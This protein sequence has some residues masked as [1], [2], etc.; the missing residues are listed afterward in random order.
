MKIVICS[1]NSKYIHSSLAPWYLLAGIREYS[2]FADNHDVVVCEGT[3]NEPSKEVYRRISVEAPDV[4]GFSC[5]IWNIEMV[6]EL[7]ALVKEKF[8]SCKIVLGGLEVS[9]NPAEVMS[10][11]PEVDFVICGEGEKPF[12]I[13]CDC[14]LS[15]KNG[16][17]LNMELYKYGVATKHEPYVEPFVTEEL[18]PTPFCK[19]Y[20]ENLNARIAYIETSRGCPY[21]CAFCLSGRCGGVRFWQTERAKQE[22][23]MLAGSGA[24]TVKF[25]DRTFNA[26]RERAYELWQFIIDSEKMYSEK[27]D[28]GIPSGVCFH[29][30]IAGD[31]L[32][33]KSLALLKTAP[34]GLIQLE[35]GLQSFNV[36]TLCLINRKTNITRLCENIKTLLSFNNMHIH[37]DLIAGLPREDLSGFKESFNTAYRLKPHALQLGFLKLLHGAD[38]REEPE[39]YPCV[40]SEKAPYEV[41]STPWMSQDDIKLLK[42]VEDVCDRL[43]N[44]GRFVRTID[45]LDEACKEIEPFDFYCAFAEYLNLLSEG[46][47]SGVGISLDKYTEM[48]WSFLNGYAAANKDIQIDFG[49]LRDLFVL[50]RLTT[51]S[52]GKL[53]GFLRVEDDRLRKV[54]LY[55]AKN[56]EFN[57]PKSTKRGVAILYSTAQAVFVDYTDKNPVTGMYE[58]RFIDL[59]KVFD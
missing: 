27:G 55:L 38:M 59:E 49:K 4:V 17:A 52:S 35:I 14:I 26:N 2:T 53:P 33:E 58:A 32:D 36:E 9:Y 7:T 25:V 41:I 19:E 45:Y 29:F 47:F 15:E 50:D 43:C 46:E 12:A 3:I 31:L 16:K 48:F 54:K 6:Y 39:K 11:H 8:P 56:E 5:Y 23:L 30:E 22:I 44:S 24:K 18:P 20:F 10:A 42:C 34:V 1:L 57:A 21:R 13:L 51:N 37:I 28:S 40:F